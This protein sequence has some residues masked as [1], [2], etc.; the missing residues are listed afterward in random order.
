MK[1]LLLCGLLL[2]SSL[3]PVSSVSADSVKMMGAGNVTCKEWSQL[4]SSME[5]FSA[6]NWV[7]GFLSSTAWNTGDDILNGKKTDGLFSAIDEFCIKMPEQTI[8]DA[9]VELAS[10]ML[11]KESEQLSTP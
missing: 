3:V 1:S 5:Y 9:A 11:D 4:R 6:A 10:F 2:T 7:L 8:A